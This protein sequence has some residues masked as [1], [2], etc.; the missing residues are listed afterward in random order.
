MKTTTKL[1]IGSPLAIAGGINLGV[2]CKINLPEFE[3][4]T[5]YPKRYFTI[6]ETADILDVSLRTVY[7]LTKRGVLLPSKFSRRIFYERF[8]LIKSIITFNL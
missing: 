2:N 5:R 7:N 8:E 3:I 4:Q 1:Q 6:N